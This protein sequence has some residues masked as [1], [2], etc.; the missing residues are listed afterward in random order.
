MKYLLVLMTIILAAYHIIRVWRTS[1]HV[2]TLIYLELIYNLCIKFL[3]GN[4]GLP[5]LLNYVTDVILILMLL[6]ALFNPRRQYPSRSIMLSFAVLFVFSIVSYIFNMYSPLLYL[7]GFRNNYRFIIFALICSAYLT[8]ED[9]KRIIKILFDF[10]LLNVLVVTYQFFFVS[11]SQSAI[12]DF[13]SGLYSNGVERGGNA[14]LNWLMCIVLTFFIVQYIN[15]EEKIL[16][17][18]ICL[19]A[20][21]YMA[22]LAEIKLFY[23]QLVIIALVAMIVGKKSWKLVVFIGAGALILWWGIQFLY[24]MFPKFA[25]FF[26]I[27]SIM[28]YTS[29]NQGYSAQKGEISINRLTVF[30]Y[31][32]ENLISGVPKI[33]FG[34][35]L[36]NADFSSY[37]F[38]VS[39]FFRI[40]SWTGYTFFYTAVLLIENG[41]VGFI[42]YFLYIFNYFKKAILLSK[43][44]VKYRVIKEFTFIIVII[45]VIMIASN[46]TMKMETS[47][48]MVHCVLAFPFIIDKE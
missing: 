41:I 27:D 13:I 28:N 45:T 20:C 18:V 17:M 14:S 5:S 26:S 37:S 34:I 8:P 39:R 16:R 46:Q 2:V 10:L 35:G 38:L 31:V 36:G 21:C 7:W 47:G 12:G 4:L 22:A 11:Y 24:I 30:S 25:D 23:L 44:N 6:E 33:L 9:I 15:K 32:Y 29:N 1:S 40:Y 42:A 3:I 48:Y 43:R 19:V